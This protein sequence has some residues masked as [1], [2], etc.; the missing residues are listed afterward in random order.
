[1]KER[2]LSWLNLFLMADLFLVLLGFFWLAIAVFGRYAGIPLGLDI[3]YKL[4]Q[5]LFTPAIGLLMLGAI[6][7]GLANQISK[8][9]T[10]V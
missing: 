3:W 4:W 7:S 1:M 6:V 10:K 9:L 5:P 2:L 8:R